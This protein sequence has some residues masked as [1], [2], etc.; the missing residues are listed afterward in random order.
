M[1]E[2]SDDS[3]RW[4]CRVATRYGW[5][6]DP[7]A[8]APDAHGA[9]DRRVLARWARRHIQRCD[10]C[11]AEAAQ[12]ERIV[13][14]LRRAERPAAPAGLL[15]RV[16]AGIAWERAQETS[17]YAAHTRPP[18][19]SALKRLWSQDDGA[20]S[21]GLLGLAWYFATA[22][23]GLGGAALLLPQGLGLLHRSLALIRAGTE[24]W[25][26]TARA[27]AV[28][29]WTAGFFPE[30]LQP[31]ASSLWWSVCGM[32]LAA[33]VVQ[34]TQRTKYDAKKR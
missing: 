13:A 9:S 6:G 32:I 11:K 3:T 12:W 23:G 14:W 25:R 28:G 21:E 19:G 5:P 30:A 17:W 15:D 33:T 8:G 1:R 31:Y 20:I 22:M 7:G 10:H 16:M 27:L 34:I 18:K 26:S 2:R 4:L 29:D 24:G